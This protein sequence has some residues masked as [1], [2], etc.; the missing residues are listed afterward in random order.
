MLQ[1]H[2]LYVV[3][4]LEIG[5]T[6]QHLAAVAQRLVRR[7]WKVSVCSLEDGP[8]REE[9]ERGEVAVMVPPRRGVA[10]GSIARLAGAAVYLL[11]ILRREKPDVVHFLLP[12]AYLFGAPLAIV[13]RTP[14]RV[15]TR[16]SLNIYQG[17]APWSRTAE[18]LLHR[19][20]HAI[21]A[22]SR[23]VMEQ[24]RNEEA[25][26]ADRLGLIYNGVDA[27][28]FSDS[29]R[30]VAL[31]RELGLDDATFVMVVVANLIQYKGHSDLFEALTIAR[32]ALP[33]DWRLLIVGRDDGIGGQLRDRARALAIDKHVQFLGQRRDIAA[34]LSASDVG[35]LSSHQEG[36]SIAVIEGMASGLAMIVTDVGGNAE[37]VVD[38]TSGLV[39]P[40]K[41]PAS[42]AQAIRRLA[43]DAGLRARFGR[44]A[45]ERV[46]Q[47]FSIEDCV[48]QHE[49]LYRAMI[50]SSR[51]PVGQILAEAAVEPAH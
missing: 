42:L 16:Q 29:S 41:D 18:R 20:M 36:F 39:V 50:A 11:S 25:A 4:T 13:T 33:E 1:P 34:I 12:A 8:L 28:L 48:R 38:G 35:I 44:A 22:V 47:H 40:P 32:P 5:G 23:R 51:L 43:T 27:A 24:L 45:R 17:N 19:K 6:E 14:I 37:A 30:R 9:F 21:L 46:Q 2:I 31:R 26:P 15:M 3:R 49:K 10:S 7:G